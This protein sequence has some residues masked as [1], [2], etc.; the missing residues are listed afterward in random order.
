MEREPIVASLTG[1]VSYRLGDPILLKVEIANQA[2]VPYQLLV[3]GTPLDR[4]LA[5][6]C[7]VV[8]RDGE[9]IP[10]DGKLVKRG[11]PPADAYVMIGSRQSLS[12][13]VDVSTAYRIDRPGRY[14]V[15]IR[16]TFFDAF[17]ARGDEMAQPRRRHEHKPLRLTSSAF[18]FRV[19][20]GDAPRLTAGQ[21][22]RK[23]SRQRLA[24]RALA[25]GPAFNGGTDAERGET[26]VA[27]NNAQY[28]AALGAARLRGGSNAARTLYGTWF[29]AFDQ[30]RYDDVTDHYTE[31]QDALLSSARTYD[32]TGNGCEAGVFA[33]THHG[34]TTVWLCSSYLSAGQ[35]GRDCKFGT[36]VHEWSHAVSGTD[37]NAYGESAC[38]TLAVD[39]PGDAV[40][41]ADSHEYFAEHLADSVRS[42]QFVFQANTGSLWVVG[43]DNRGDLKLGMMAGTSP[44]VCVLPDG[45]LQFA[46][47][48]NTGNLWVVGAD[49]RGDLKFG[50]MAGTSPSICALPGGGWAA[51]FQANTSNLWVVGAD[52]RG[53]LKLGMMAGTSPSVCV[54]PDGSLQFAFQANTGNLWVVGADN[55]GDLKFGMMA[56]TSPSIC[57]LPGGGWVVAFQA[58]TGNL[59]VVGA[60]NRGDLKF[61]MM[62]GTSPSI[63]A[64]PGGGWAAAFQAN[65]GNLWVVGADNRGDLKFGMMAGTSPSICALP[66]G[67]WAAAFQA[68]TGNLWVVGA[69]NRG[70]L[71]FGMKPGTSPTVTALAAV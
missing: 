44:S 9:L 64:L 38:Q 34:D 41:N 61:G 36:L 12:A 52:N 15:S 7:L 66:G 59:W 67:G 63:C 17:T 39:D 10:Y 60:D 11:D 50:M 53:D 6:D 51:A 70:D 20:P 28:F 46:F 23:A 8:R 58:N 30:G 4:E 45:S 65:T 2:A 55:R 29:G 26:V 40:D 32:L 54:L 31:I 19:E 57:A 13:T 22:A 14:A 24:G 47:Q 69:D 62:A 43:A 5:G 21:A 1:S 16:A 3:W 18:R 37:D 48:A 35:F 68:N 33:Y 49:N 56:G 42:L 25:R 27:H 71:T